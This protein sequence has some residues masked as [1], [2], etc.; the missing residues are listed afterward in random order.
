ML[1]VIF[2]LM[3]ARI[4]ARWHSALTKELQEAT[5]PA[6]I[7]A[8]WHS[9]CPYMDSWLPVLVPICEHLFVIAHGNTSPA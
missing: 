2:N 3:A 1:F 8:L 6:V 9:Q 7:P 4:C 5:F